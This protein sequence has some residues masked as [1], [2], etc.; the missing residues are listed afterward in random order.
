M[1]QVFLNF[2]IETVMTRFLKRLQNAAFEVDG[3]FD[4]VY[5]PI[6]PTVHPA[7]YPK[8]D[9][10]IVVGFGSDKDAIRSDFRNVG[11]DLREGIEKAKEE[12]SL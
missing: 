2:A 7:E 5:V 3:M 11:N 1:R 8:P 10:K 9:L 12:F 4:G 6:V